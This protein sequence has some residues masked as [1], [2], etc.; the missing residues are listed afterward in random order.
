MM[1]PSTISCSAATKPSS[2]QRTLFGNGK[3]RAVT[4]ARKNGSE[5]KATSHTGPP[6][7]AACAAAPK[8]RINVSDTRRKQLVARPDVVV[9][10]RQLLTNVGAEYRD[11]TEYLRVYMGRL[12]RKLDPDPANPRYL[13]TEPNIGYRFT[14]EAHAAV[15][16]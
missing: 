3:A 6:S 11:D 7:S 13:R 10:H 8:R 12:G 15:G 2:A 5:T 1:H 16:A 9:S 4:P 14:P